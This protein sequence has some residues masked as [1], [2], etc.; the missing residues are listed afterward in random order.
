MTNTAIG[1][2][3]GLSITELEVGSTDFLVG[4]V[5]VNVGDVKRSKKR[6]DKPVK[7]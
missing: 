3:C 5:G 6:V 7:K 4:E 2:P 1:G